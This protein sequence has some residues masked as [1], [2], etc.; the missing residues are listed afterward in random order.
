MLPWEDDNPELIVDAAEDEDHFEAVMQ[1]L[2]DELEKFATASYPSGGAVWRHADFVAST[3]L[4][5]KGGYDDG[6]LGR[7]TAEDLAEYMLGY[8]PRKVSVEP[9]TLADVPE[10][11]VAFLRLLDDRGSLSGEP[12]EELEQ[13]C[14]EL[15]EEFQARAGSPDSWGLAKSMAMQMF[16]EGIDPCE[17]GAPDAWITGFNSRPRVDRDAVVGGASERMLDAAK[18]GPGSAARKPASQRRTQRKAQRVA[19]KRSRRRG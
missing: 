4:Q 12:L 13:V 6:R 2:L 17:P 11:I 1:L 18:P 15:R 3:M 7:W 9:E 10:C 8:F 5:W 16:A 14:T 19:R